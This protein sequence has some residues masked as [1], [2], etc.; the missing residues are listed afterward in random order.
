MG[1]SAS[2]QHAKH[3]KHHNTTE[4]LQEDFHGLLHLVLSDPTS[5]RFHRARL[6]GYDEVMGDGFRARFSRELLAVNA[7]QDAALYGFMLFANECQMPA[8][9]SADSSC[10]G[11]VKKL[12]H[13]VATAFGGSA[14]SAGDLQERWEQR[15]EQLG[16][17][18]LWDEVPIGRLLGMDD[19]GGAGL[20][21]HRAILFKY[22][23]DQLAICPSALVALDGSGKMLPRDSA[24]NIVWVDGEPLLVDLFT[25]PGMLR[26]APELHN[27]I[28]HEARCRMGN[29][30]PTVG[31]PEADY[32][33]PELVHSLDSSMKSSEPG[34]PMARAIEALSPSAASPVQAFIYDLSQGMAKSTSQLILGRQLELVPHT[35]IVVFG[36]EYFLSAGPQVGDPGQT[37]PLPVSQRLDLGRTSRSRAE[38]EDYIFT[39]LAREF[40]EANYDLMHRNCNHFA[41][42]VAKYLLQGRGIPGNLVTMAE[43]VLS[44]PE[45]QS[46]RIMVQDAEQSLR[47][48]GSPTAGS[49]AASS[50]TAAKFTFGLP[51]ASP[52]HKDWV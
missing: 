28:A 9:G 3:A 31:S 10:F 22:C 34:S 7:E 24:V 41:D 39:T 18:E 8:V 33:P 13:A 27:L 26:T 5:V 30:G 43:E 1:A 48:R 44:R 40:T 42:A 15:M 35:A 20:Q 6:L 29:V 25:D 16:L 23:C 32:W 4:Q 51:D 11:R 49:F 14:G 50:P 21:R 52:K 2:K 38:L 17:E 45:G 46:L 19:T 47:S 12:A 37:V 36:R